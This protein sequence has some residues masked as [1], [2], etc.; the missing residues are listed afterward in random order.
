MII[1]GAVRVEEE[2]YC[3]S[4]LE[5]KRLR[6]AESG[7]DAQNA[8]RARQEAEYLR[9]AQQ[10]Y[11]TSLLR[12]RE[13]PDDPGLRHQALRCGRLYAA[14]TRHKQ[15]TGV[16]LFDEVALANDIQ[17]ACAA[18]AVQRPPSAGEGVEERLQRLQ[19]L[20]QKGLIS[21]QEYETKRGEVLA[22]L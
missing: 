9:Q 1:F 2:S 12:L 15:G 16:T 5:T 21:D 17:A 13:K 8:E 19:Q 14:W 7:Q 10:A 4:C 6:E 20:R 22:N 18:A 3:R 11:E